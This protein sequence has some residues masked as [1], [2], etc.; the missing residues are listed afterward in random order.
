MQKQKKGTQSWELSKMAKG[1]QAIDI[2]DRY[3]I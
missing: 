1:W 3:N 2:M